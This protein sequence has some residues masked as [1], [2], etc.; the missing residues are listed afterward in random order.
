MSI[1]GSDDLPCLHLDPCIR[2]T[3]NMDSTP[4]AAHRSIQIAIKLVGGSGA[5][6]TPIL[7]NV[8]FGTNGWRDAD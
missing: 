4:C 2:D 8:F 7:D 1:A 5:D 3:F 6:N